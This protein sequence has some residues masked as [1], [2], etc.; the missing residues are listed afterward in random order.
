MPRKKKFKIFPSLRLL[1]FCPKGL[2]LYF[3]PL[4]PQGTDLAA[5]GFGETDPQRG[6]RRNRK[7]RVLQGT[8]QVIGGQHAQIPFHCGGDID[9]D[10]LDAAIYLE[11]K[12]HRK[13]L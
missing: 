7:H 12:V 5:A 4:A 2:T 1:P 10:L 13:N 6:R 11:C 8:G 9:R 3:N